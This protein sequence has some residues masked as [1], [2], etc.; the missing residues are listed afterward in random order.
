MSL[1]FINKKTTPLLIKEISF[2][3]LPFFFS[4]FISVDVKKKEKNKEEKHLEKSKNFNSRETWMKLW[5]FARSITKNFT[6]EHNILS[7]QQKSLNFHLSRN[8]GVFQPHDQLFHSSN[9]RIYQGL[10]PSAISQSSQEISLSHQDNIEI[11]PC[12]SRCFSRKKS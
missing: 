3:I 1:S 7:T 6:Q 8:P 10:S 5:V 2:L 4:S 9:H 11:H 12:K